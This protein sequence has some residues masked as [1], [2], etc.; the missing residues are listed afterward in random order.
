M[1]YSNDPNRPNLDDQARYRE[2][3]AEGERSAASRDSS[4]GGLGFLLG[5]V[6]LALL[7]LLGWFLIGRN[8]TQS[9]ETQ[10]PQGETNIIN[11]PA[12][13]ALEAPSPNIQ[14]PDVNITVPS[15]NVGGGATTPET[16]GGTDTAPTSP[17]NAQ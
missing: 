7:G 4:S 14:Q 9:P 3:Y 2:G 16:G 1:S 13:E 11:V 6:L 12:P 10:A 17:G 5:I 15:P 8:T